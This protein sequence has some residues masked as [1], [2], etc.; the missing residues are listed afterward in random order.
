MALVMNLQLLT[1]FPAASY[2]KPW[3]GAQ[4]AALVTSGV[5]VTLRCRAPQ[6]TWRFALFKSGEVAPVLYRD[7]SVE[8]A[9]FFLEEVSPDQG[10]NYRS[11]W[12]S[13]RPVRGPSPLPPDPGVQAPGPSSL[14]PRGSGSPD[15]TQCNL[16]RL[17]LAGLVLMSLGTLV[18]FDWRRQTRRCKLLYMEW[19]NNKVLL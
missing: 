12:A 10:G 2:P 16:V 17:G 8:L 19:I 5:N 11:R 4:P 9:E 3:L 13:A 15:Y 14:S 18:V 6:P 7:V 1:L